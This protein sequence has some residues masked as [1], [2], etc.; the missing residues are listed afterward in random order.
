MAADKLTV[1][2]FIFR[3]KQMDERERRKI[4]A[5]DLIEIIL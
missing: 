4:R 1:E 2:N 3:I 5:Q